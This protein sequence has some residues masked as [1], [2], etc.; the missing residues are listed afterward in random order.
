[1]RDA[2]SD[3]SV[4]GKARSLIVAADYKDCFDCLGDH[5]LTEDDKNPL[6]KY[7]NFDDDVAG[8][9]KLL[10]EKLEKITRV[11][12]H[13]NK[14]VELWIDYEWQD[15]RLDDEATKLVRRN[16][17]AGI[18]EKLHMPAIYHSFGSHTFEKD[19]NTQAATSKK[20]ARYIT[21][22]FFCTYRETN[23]NKINA[24]AARI[25]F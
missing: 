7:S 14:N 13:T 6:K 25:I 19:K 5:R 20:H 9:G 17:I 8:T 21:L 24:H 18:A 15:N 22:S 10:K 1:M 16:D 2:K 3:N 11:N 23:C 4:G 12:G